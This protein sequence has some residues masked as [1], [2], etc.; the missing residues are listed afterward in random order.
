MAIPRFRI[1]YA[2]VA[3]TIALIMACGG[4]AYAAGVLPRHSVG[5]PQLKAGA[6]TTA[7]L[8]DASV[9]RSRLARGSVRSAAVAD[10]ALRVADLAGTDISGGV[11]LSLAAGACTNVNLA[12]TGARP[13][14]VAVFAWTG[15]SNPS[16]L[17]S[18]P[19]RVSAANSVT[20]P[21]C[22][23]SASTV[24]VTDAQVRI[25]TFD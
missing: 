7:K 20:V 13:G 8:H 18:G 2:D 4:T 19:P 21:M 6:V 15:T 5:T 25:I 10:D 16:G 14:Q 1:R 22:N 11:S 24:T 23:G 9:T 17:M 12:V 3:A